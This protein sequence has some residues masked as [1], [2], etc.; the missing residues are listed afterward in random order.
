L[1]DV[2]ILFSVP[3]QEIPHFEVTSVAGTEAADNSE[4]L[5]VQGDI[6]QESNVITT[7][8][9]NVSHDV[10][11]SQEL[12]FVEEASSSVAPTELNSFKEV[13]SRTYRVTKEDDIVTQRSETTTVSD[14]R[15]KSS[16]P[17]GVYRQ[18]KKISCVFGSRQQQAVPVFLPKL[19]NSIELPSS[20]TG[21]CSYRHFSLFLCGV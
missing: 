14:L 6:E 2:E 1:V 8:A 7:L 4:D 9:E 18:S 11:E 16:V 21:G 20:S 15:R 5:G 19:E 12:P 3:Q 17:F 13:E 10:D